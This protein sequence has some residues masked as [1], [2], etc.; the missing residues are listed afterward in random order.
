M[1]V[2]DVLNDKLMYTAGKFGIKWVV[3]QA[4]KFLNLVR[5]NKFVEE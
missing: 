1:A 4:I 3:M 5:P 2:D